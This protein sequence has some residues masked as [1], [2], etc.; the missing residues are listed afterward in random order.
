MGP[1]REPNEEGEGGP[2]EEGGGVLEGEGGAEDCQAEAGADVR[3]RG[4]RDGGG[5]EFCNPVS[6]TSLNGSNHG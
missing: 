4:A 1:S 2:E 3:H 5:L 6:V